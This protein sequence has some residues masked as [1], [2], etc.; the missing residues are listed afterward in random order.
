VYPDPSGGLH[1]QTV[2][3]KLVAD[4]PCAIEWRFGVEGEWRQY[5]DSP[6][7]ISQTATLQ[8]RAVDSCGNELETK[9]ER[10][11]VRPSTEASRCAADM[12]LVVIGAT[13][14][15]IDKYEWPDRKGT[16]PAAYVSLYQAMDSCLAARKRLCS[17]EEWKLACSGPYGWA[18]PYGAEFER[19]ACVT[20][21][22]ASAPSG[23]RPECRGYFEVF[24]M[25]GNLAE[26]TST[27][28][29]A[30]SRFFNVMGGFYESGPQSGCSGVRYSYFP[31]NRHN[32]VGFRCCADAAAARQGAAKQ[33]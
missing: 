2:Q 26:W 27:R 10:Y 8:Y 29:T 18:Y 20:Y 1:R 7:V 6:V 11:E 32:P 17:T 9:S 19:R 31:Q 22:T 4:K 25:S 28:A 15:C 5:A 13:T 24:D 12:E 21:D 16:R 3:V 30:D 14:F 23:S 33:P